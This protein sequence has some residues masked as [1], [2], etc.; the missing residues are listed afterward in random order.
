MYKSDKKWLTIVNLS[1]EQNSENKSFL[2][3]LDE[4]DP[5]SDDKNQQKSIID[6]FTADEPPDPNATYC[7]SSEIGTLIAQKI[8]NG[9]KIR[10]GRNGESTDRSV[11]NAQRSSHHEL[12][13][14]ADNSHEKNFSRLSEENGHQ[15]NY[16]VLSW[17]DQC[18]KANV[19]ILEPKASKM[20]EEKKPR[21]E[22]NL[23]ITRKLNEEEQFRPKVKASG[24]TLKK[25][26]ANEMTRTQ[27]K[28]ATANSRQSKRQANMVQIVGMSTASTFVQQQQ[29]ARS[30]E[31]NHHNQTGDLQQQHNSKEFVIEAS[32]AG[33]QFESISEPKIL[34]LE[35]TL[36]P[37]KPHKVD[38]KMASKLN[39]RNYLQ[40]IENL[41]T[42]FTTNTSNNNKNDKQQTNKR[43]ETAREKKT[44]SEEMPRPQSEN[45]MLRNLEKKIKSLVMGERET[46]SLSL[47]GG[48]HQSSVVTTPP[49][50]R[51]IPVNFYQNRPLSASIPYRSNKYI[52]LSECMDESSNPLY[53]KKNNLIRASHATPTPLN[54]H[55]VFNSPNEAK[56]FY[57][58]KKPTSLNSNDSAASK[59][60]FI[61]LAKPM[62]ATMRANNRSTNSPKASDANLIALSNRDSQQSNHDSPRIVTKVIIP[63]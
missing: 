11:R 28:S 44:S 33:A 62:S 19:R 34:N 32:T 2:K 41:T 58:K 59:T 55:L 43:R 4:F 60:R 46:S 29:Q 48:G 61:N 42:K 12:S 25:T 16:S 10:I 54:R 30:R 22:R 53:R 63:S 47:I 49:T 57:S 36:V 38:T 23:I 50:T 18:T 35:R 7:V 52:Q 51:K 20:G 1:E 3:H 9:D 40:I 13:D 15:S 37:A 27:P 31:S 6:T 17:Q 39:E 56:E 5:M 26:E 8:L 24:L 21:R 14:I 45:Q